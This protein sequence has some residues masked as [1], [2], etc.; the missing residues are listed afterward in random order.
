MTVGW[1]FNRIERSRFH[2]CDRV[3]S[4][5]TQ[6]GAKIN[7]DRG[8]SLNIPRQ[9]WSRSYK[10]SQPYPSE[11]FFAAGNTDN[12]E[13]PIIRWDPREGIPHCRL[14]VSSVASR[15]NFTSPIIYVNDDRRIVHHK[16]GRILVSAGQRQQEQR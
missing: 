7:L 4:L 8:N 3:H 5:F 15:G 10:T 13:F 1:P 16:T 11:F 9:G 14:T 2:V 6:S 12:F